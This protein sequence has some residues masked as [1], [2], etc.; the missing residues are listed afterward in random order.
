MKIQDIKG[1]KYPDDYFIK[2]FFKHGFQSVQNYLFLELGSSNGCNLTLPYQYGLDVMG[3][4]LNDTLIN[5]A[6]D[7]FCNLQDKNSYKFI[8]EDMREFCKNSSNINADILV[9]ASS[10]YYIP[11]ND[12][13]ELLKNIKKNN[14]IKQNISLFIRFRE[15]DDFR[16]GK[17][18]KIDENGYI[19]NNGITGE[20]GAFCQFY[21]TNEMIHI[22]KQELD[23]RDFQTMSL[24]YDNIQ[25]NKRVNNSEVVIWGTIN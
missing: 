17:G 24:K 25:N 2:Y 5:F 13:I 11:K 9:L 12:F 7:N 23:L 8:S 14:L 20:D 21:D 16:N 15:I 3:V 6:N 22:L 19:L 18:E 1:L 4:D 10:I